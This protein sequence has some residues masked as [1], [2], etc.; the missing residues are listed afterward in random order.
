MISLLERSASYRKRPGN[1]QVFD[2]R[3][4][5]EPLQSSESQ[6]SVCLPLTD[7]KSQMVSAQGS[8]QA[9]LK[10][11][12][13]QKSPDSY[14][15]E[16]I[17]DGKPDFV[18]RDEIKDAISR[19]LARLKT[20]KDSSGTI[21][22]TGKESQVTK[23]SVSP[24]EAKRR[25]EVLRKRPELQKLH[26]S[27]VGGGL[28]SDAQ[29]WNGVWFRLNES[30]QRW[31]NNEQEQDSVKQ[32]RGI[33]SEILSEISPVEEKGKT[34]KYRLTQDIIH[35]IFLEEPAVHLAYQNYV[36][37]K[38]SEQAFWTQYFQSRYI[39]QG[40]K[41]EEAEK[42]DIFTPFEAQIERNKNWNKE[43]LK[44]VEKEIN[45]LLDDNPY[46]NG[47]GINE[48][49]MNDQT[50][51]DPSLPLLE[52]LNR[53]SSLVVEASNTSSYNP[54]K[55]DLHQTLTEERSLQTQQQQQLF[56]SPYS[57]LPS[58]KPKSRQKEHNCQYLGE[59]LRSASESLQIVEPSIKV[60]RSVLQ[61]LFENI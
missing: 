48:H 18:S 45:L 8:K 24:E 21:E 54:S 13:N 41:S 22:Q 20:G 43:T 55:E 12:T 40:R 27:L 9:L 56:S 10:L 47:Y 42:N 51:E 23:V 4:N 36:P 52:R 37:S 32:K 16:F 26:M 29:F 11:T 34:V 61:E 15:F 58:V 50:R 28:I 6:T 5:W 53:H 35:K 49:D 60:S 46:Q 1:L 59:R 44:N 2:N 30:E 57:F 7:I 33:S 19:Q 38:M 17:R 14:V 31:L 3:V 39:H 25:L